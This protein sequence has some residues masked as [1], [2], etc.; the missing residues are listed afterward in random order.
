[1]KKLIVANWKMY[2]GFR[3]SVVL[4]RCLAKLE[5]GNW[6]LEVVVCPSFVALS[7]VAKVVKGTRVKLGAQDVEP[8]ARGAHTGEVGLDDLGEIGV[9]YVLVGHSERR[10]KGEDDAFINRKL[11]AVLKAGMRPILCVGELSAIREAGQAEFHVAKQLRVGWAGVPEI[12]LKRVII[13]YEP[14]W[15][16]GTGNPAT[17]EIVA[18]MHAQVR[19]NMA[20]KTIP[21]IYGGSV[22]AKN[23]AAFLQA[24]GVDGL[25]IGGASTRAEEFLQI[26]TQV[27]K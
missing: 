13:A 23:A 7:E 18:T 3:E 14:I 17:P 10:A 6:K 9:Q 11:Q 24:R 8:E 12:A 15:A 1:M 20:I 4:A 21:I 26:L 19:K 2:L 22:G 25:L 27:G 5:I 16:I